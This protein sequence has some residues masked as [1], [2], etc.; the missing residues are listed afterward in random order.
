M[1]I[2]DLPNVF[3]LPGP[4]FLL[5]YIAFG[6]IVMGA[7]YVLFLVSD[8]AAPMPRLLGDPYQIAGLR[9]GPREAARIGVLSLVDRNL[10][11]IRGD[12]LFV[13]PGNRA[14]LGLN[15]IER[16]IFQRCSQSPVMARDIPGDPRV[17]A[18]CAA[19]L[20]PLIA[21]GLVPDA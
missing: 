8:S 6:A 15:P 17:S 21:T 18:A 2:L 20:G 5:F 12:D 16:A 10:A 4:Q 9:G 13:P 19:M 1:D 7:L 3:D 11:Q 14:P